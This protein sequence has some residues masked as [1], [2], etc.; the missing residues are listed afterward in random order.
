[1]RPKV[2]LIGVGRAN[3]YGHPVPYVLERLSAVG[4]AVFR[5][6]L[7]GEVSVSTDGNDV[8]VSTFTGRIWKLKDSHE[9]HEGSK[10]M[11]Q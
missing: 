2:A 1:M 7:D 5:T 4:T 11:I 6:D 8:R 10:G 9:G 3:P